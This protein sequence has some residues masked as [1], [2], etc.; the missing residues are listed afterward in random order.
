MGGYDMEVKFFN[1]H[2]PITQNH[3]NSKKNKNSVLNQ[4]NFQISA[5]S[6]NRTSN[7][8]SY[9]VSFGFNLFDPFG[10]KKSQEK[11]VLAEIRQINKENIESILHYL[12][13]DRKQV[14]KTAISQLHKFEKSEYADSVI[15]LLKDPEVGVRATAADF[16]RDL[17][18]TE[19]RRQV[20]PLLTEESYYIRLAAV[21]AL[22]LTKDP[23]YK[24]LFKNI[25]KT[26]R[27]SLVVEAA[28]LA[29]AEIGTKEDI[30]FII[31]VARR[32]SLLED[33]AKDV[34]KEIKYKSNNQ[35]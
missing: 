34:I 17:G 5:D 4:T 29:F 21:E 28:M 18:N 24:D 25:M 27:D 12:K 16:I 23:E 11:K 3:I 19:Q 33:T 2:A 31:K 8:S 10:R 30:P 6:F 32:S 13:D 1:Q 9:P 35:K 22:A 15:P 26:D 20:L 7:T 14:R